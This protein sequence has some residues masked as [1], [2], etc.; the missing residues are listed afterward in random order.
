MSTASYDLTYLQGVAYNYLMDPDILEVCFGGAKGGGKS[1]LVGIYLITQCLKYPNSRWLLGRHKLNRLLQTTVVTIK[2]IAREMGIEIHHQQQP[3]HILRIGSSEILCVSLDNTEGEA[4]AKLGSLEVC[5]C[6]VD[7]A[8]EISFDVYSTLITLCRYR[9]DEFGLTPKVLVCTNPTKNWVKSRFYDRWR[10]DT[11]PKGRKFIQVLP[12]DNEM[13]PKSYLEALSLENLGPE[14]YACWI[15][16]DWEYATD[17]IGVFDQRDV[18]RAIGRGQVEPTFPRY[19]TIDIAAG[20]GLDNTVFTYWEGWN[21]K[22]IHVFDKEI[23]ETIAFARQFISQ[24]NIAA[25]HVVVDQT[26]LG[27]AVHQALRG[28]VGF[29]ANQRPIDKDPYQNVK[30]QTFYKFAERLRKGEVS[31]PRLDPDMQK[32]MVDE[33]DS[34]TTWNQLNDGKTAINPKKDQM[35]RNNGR[36]PDIL[37]SLIMREYLALKQG[38][39]MFFQVLKR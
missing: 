22:E 12:K 18:F 14:K 28:S 33:F 10:D 26:G 8:A 23:S 29:H 5:A 25:H 31:L 36:S 38:S 24:K 34:V 32:R 20:V 30:A 4:A 17:N 9:L 1:R 15:E 6:I 13:L 3:N 21:C 7:E 37:D 19:L 11:L 27:I 35:N 2:E 16:G 39:G